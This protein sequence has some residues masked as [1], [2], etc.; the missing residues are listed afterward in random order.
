M[1]GFEDLLGD[2]FIRQSRPYKA[3]GIFTILYDSDLPINAASGEIW[4]IDGGKKNTEQFLVEAYNEDYLLESIKS[5]LGKNQTVDGKPWA[6]GFSGL[7][8]ITKI[9][10]SFIG[11]K[12]KGIGLAFNNFSPVQD[13]SALSVSAVPAPKTIYILLFIL[14][15]LTIHTNKKY[16]RINKA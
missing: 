9:E 6:F 4:D 16:C 12:T 10:I 14:S 11:T 5:P 3:F 13:R 8:N 2:F 7:T 15:F 1:E